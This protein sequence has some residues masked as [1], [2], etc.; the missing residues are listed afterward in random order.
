MTEIMEADVRNF[1]QTHSFREA[2]FVV[3]NPLIRY[4]GAWKDKFALSLLVKLRQQVVCRVVHGNEPP[5]FL[6]LPFA[7]QNRPVS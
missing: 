1:R 3:T 6:G 7:D 4:P 2:N 5:T